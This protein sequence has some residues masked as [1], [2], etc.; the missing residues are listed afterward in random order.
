MDK[1]FLSTSLI[2]PTQI[3]GN[4]GQPFQIEENEVQIIFYKPM[5]WIVFETFLNLPYLCCHTY[6]LGFTPNIIC[7]PG[8]AKT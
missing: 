4:A 8:K 5:I 6:K 3:G 1:T 2:N 7:F